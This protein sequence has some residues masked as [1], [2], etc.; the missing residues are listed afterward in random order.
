MPPKDKPRM[1][2]NTIFFFCSK[3][4]NRN[5]K[6]KSQIL[7]VLVV[8]GVP[9]VNPALLA[10][11]PN[12]KPVVVA[13]V[14]PIPPNVGRD[15]VLVGALNANPVKLGLLVGGMLAWVPNVDAA[16]DGVPK[17]K[18]GIAVAPKDNVVAG[19]GDAKEPNAGALAAEIY[20]IPQFLF[21]IQINMCQKNKVGFT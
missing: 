5:I 13:G 16:V 19:A 15:E 7:P 1:K 8:A 3:D 4:H 20:K 6:N 11:V 9:R 14:V 12:V 21:N 17:F 18:G 10:G 2:D